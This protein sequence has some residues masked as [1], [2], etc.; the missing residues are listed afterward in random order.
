MTGGDKEKP[1]L[2][3]LG[4]SS[5]CASKDTEETPCP[6]ALGPPGT[7][8]AR[9]GTVSPLSCPQHPPAMPVASRMCWKE[10][11]G[12]EPWSAMA[13]GGSFMLPGTARFSKDFGFGFCLGVSERFVQSWPPILCFN[14]SLER[15]CQ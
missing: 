6:E 3:A 2:G 8:P 10:S 11:L 9:L 1:R 5:L 15:F 7:A 4:H 12:K 13:L 14:E